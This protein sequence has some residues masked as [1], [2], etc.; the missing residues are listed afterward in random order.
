MGWNDRMD[1][2]DGITG[3]LE[4]LV[5][6]GMLDDTANGITKRVIAQGES[7]LSDKQRYVFEKRVIERFSTPE[8]TYCHDDI[9][10]PEMF[11]AHMNGGY[12]GRCVHR[13][14]KDLADIGKTWE[15]VYGADE[16]VVLQ[17]LYELHKI[18]KNEQERKAP[19]RRG[20]F[21]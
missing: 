21:D 11:D 10:W 13:L 18:T 20:F 5:D 15:D 2:D 1:E 3:F 17:D 7:G 16:D 19:K 6:Y 14:C 9:P 12:C 8:C 4:E